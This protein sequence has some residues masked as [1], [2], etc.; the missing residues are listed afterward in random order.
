VKR[1]KSQG[2]ALS[3][4][5]EREWLA[6]AIRYRRTLLGLKQRDLSEILDAAGVRWSQG[7]IAK[8][9]NATR[10]VSLF[11]LFAV[12]I[13]L[14]TTPEGLLF[15]VDDDGLWVDEVVPGYARFDSGAR[16]LTA[17]LAE[18]LD[19]NPLTGSTAAAWTFGT[20]GEIDLEAVAD[21]A[22]RY[23]ADPDAV[24]IAEILGTTVEQVQGVIAAQ[25]PT[26]TGWAGQTRR[27]RWTA[28]ELIDEAVESYQR[29]HGPV[30]GH[31]L[32]QVRTARTRELAALVGEQL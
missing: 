21:L 6:A 12:C 30:E 26:I 17:A 19:G 24:T 27:K 23:A 11:E 14:G 18:L 25:A 22:A 3:V 16:V 4:A 9:E 20:L 15:P 29:E 13:A 32:R 28:R 2:R 7:V 31:A 10:D 1:E 5:T 8:V